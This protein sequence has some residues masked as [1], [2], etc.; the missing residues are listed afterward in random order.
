MDNSTFSS[1]NKTYPLIFDGHN[2]VLSR[3]W[4]KQSATPHRDFLQ[5]D[6]LGHLDLPRMKT[7]G[8]CG[9][10]FAIYVPPL[11]DGGL[12]FD[13]MDGENGYDLPLPPEIE[14]PSALEVVLQ[15][16]ALLSAIERA[17]AGTTKICLTANDV[18]QCKE[19]DTLAMVMHMEGAEA[20]DTDFY[21]LEVLYRAGLRS[22]GPVWSRPTAF[23]HGVPFRFPGSPDTGPGLTDAGKALVRALNELRMVID[24]SHLNEKGFWDVARL[25]DSPLIATHSNAHVLCA[26]T[27]NLTDRQ[28][29]AIRD[30]DGLVG[31]NFATSFIRADGRMRANTSLDELLSHT[32]YLIEQL[33]EDRVGFGSD[34]DGAVVP[35]DMGDVTGLRSLRSAMVSRGYDNTLLEKLCHRNWFAVLERVFGH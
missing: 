31:V 8:F 33:G 6:G 14:L 29:A 12:P 2:D 4:E 5:G 11:E 28:L 34:F 20:I 18:R 30:S 1:S 26:S 7:G 13:A 32:D 22:V 10:L 24:L 16:A 23:G 17:S 25:S 21:N 15:Q 35:T 9:G 3:L 27:R 19:A